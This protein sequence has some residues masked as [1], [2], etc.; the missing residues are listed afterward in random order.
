LTLPNRLGKRNDMGE[1][2]AVEA[3]HATRRH[4]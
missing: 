3:Q 4:R 2:L 1:E